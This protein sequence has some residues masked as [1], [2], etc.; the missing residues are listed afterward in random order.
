MF[1]NIIV[2]AL[3]AFLLLPTSSKAITIDNF[4]QDLTAI[5]GTINVTDQ[6]GQLT[7]NAIGG[8]RKISA[9]KKTGGGSTR[10]I[11]ETFEGALSH[12]QDNG[13][14]A[15]SM[16]T[17]D[18]VSSI[19]LNPAGLGGI[20]LTQDGADAFLL[21]ILSFD[22]P[23]AS[24][25]VLTLTVYDASDNSGN[26]FSKTTVTLNQVIIAPA[27]VSIPFSQLQG[28]AN[29]NNVGAITFEVGSSSSPAPSAVDLSI[30][31]IRTNGQC[32]QIPG[33]AGK[34]ID[35]CGVCG[36]DGQSC[37]D[38]EGV[39]FGTKILDRCEVCGGD[40]Q[41]CLECNSKDITELLASMDGGAKEFEKVIGKILNR[42]KKL[43]GD[44]KTAAFV[45]TTKAK[46]HTLQVRNWI[47]SWTIPR[48]STKCA[49]L[50][51]CIES[52]NSVFVEEYRTHEN[53]LNAIAVDALKRL[54]KA[55]A[56]KAEVA[57]HTKAVQKVHGE[58]IGRLSQVPETQSVCI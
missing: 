13:V 22:F 29:L 36:G 52:S 54:A 8:A 31:G 10:V 25:V 38:C 7:N 20:D 33:I 45:K 3:G 55:K 2:W 19:G 46:V 16:L 27:T 43:K 40:G 50:N 9:T 15:F 56:T 23:N 41:S 32:T 21:D 24:P 34:V 58:N 48:I 11:V 49:N 26:T 12:S 37:L 5:S 44:A 17:W 4:T 28:N 18:G 39:P 42:I 6:Q 47:L 53:E 1:R 30:D 51:F 14:T 57:R 35:Q